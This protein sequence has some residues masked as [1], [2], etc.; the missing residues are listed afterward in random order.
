M[1]HAEVQ[2]AQESVERKR[3]AKAF[4]IFA[5]LLPLLFL[6]YAPLTDYTLAGFIFDDGV[7]LLGAQSIADG[8]GYVLPLPPL[9]PPI[10]KY[11]PLFSLLLAPVWWLHPQFPENLFDFNVVVLSL[12]LCALPLVFRLAKEHFQNSAIAF[13]VVALVALSNEFAYYATRILSEG[14]YLLI[15]LIA[16]FALQR[17]EKEPAPAIGLQKLLPA[18]LCSALV[19][20]TRSLGSVFILAG[21]L[22]LFLTQ[23][24]R[25]ALQYGAGCLM[26]CLPWFLWT[27]FQQ[28][29]NPFF[30]TV[31]T[32]DYVLYN[33][34]Q[35][36]SEY[37]RICLLY[38][39]DLPN[40]LASGIQDLLQC[41]PPLLMPAFRFIH[42]RTWW[43][44][45]LV[46]WNILLLCPMLWVGF[47]SLR[48]KQ[49]SLAGI[50]VLLYFAVCIAWNDHQFERFF[51][52][53]LPFVWVVLLNGYRQV[54]QYGMEK[55]KALPHIAR[56]LFPGVVLFFVLQHAVSFV[57]YIGQQ[58]SEAYQQKKQATWLKYQDVFQKIVTLT[59]RDGI[60]MG[61][62]RPMYL[63]YTQRKMVYLNM[64]PRRAETLTPTE[65]QQVLA[66]SEAEMAKR[67]NAGYLLDE[68][69]YDAIRLNA[70]QHQRL[71]SST[72]QTITLYKIF[73]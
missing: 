8:A 46:V 53:T 48:T 23:K 4:W 45:S 52:A 57:D 67:L 42:N 55:M 37:Y 9:N 24:K 43:D 34:F 11:P 5:V 35:S 28:A 44:V 25:L 10:I 69:G 60:I 20:Y 70:I 18:V 66:Q 22:W 3:S 15:S 21:F 50:Y 41:I 39:G 2:T 32:Q 1:A 19:F 40:I 47:H 36:Y 33:Y 31:V 62:H 12:S 26:A 73:P 68:H 72:D 38:M 65:K 14:I 16:Y 30:A 54:L 17:L 51:V 56:I 7:Y 59:P 27:S 29:S 49:F 64:I 63:L 13:G 6:V 58:T 71:F 61:T